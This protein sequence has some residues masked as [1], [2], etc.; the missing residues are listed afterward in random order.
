M[1]PKVSELRNG[2]TDTSVLRSSLPS[3]DT[4]RPELFRDD[5]WKP[6]FAKLRAEDPVHYCAESRHGPY[7]SV[8][9][10]ADIFAIETDTQTFSS[11]YLLGGVQ[12]SDIYNPTL[13]TMD[14]PDHTARRKAMTPVV[15]PKNL[16][17]FEKLIR[18]RTSAVLDSLPRN[19]EFDWVER[20]SIELT[21][22]MLATLF[23][24]PID[25]RQRLIHWSDVIAADLEDPDSPIRTE[26]ERMAVLGEFHSLMNDAVERSRRAPMRFDVISLLAHNDDFVAAPPEE[27]TTTFSVL[28]VGGNDT[29]RNS[30]SGGL[31]GLSQNP[32]QMELLKSRPDLVGNAVAE[33]IR[34]QTPVISM[35][36]TATRN[37]EL[38]GRQIQKGEKVVMWYVSGNRDESLFDD[39]DLIRVDRHNA[40]QHIAFGMGPHR[41]LGSRLAELQLRILWEEILARDL[42][43]EV[44]GAPSYAYSAFVRTV[45]SLPVK[46]RH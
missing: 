1:F 41:C 18:E 7:W 21:S 3:I 37:V 15:S 29:T 34:F 26:S 4:S 24:H 13:I 23:G 2:M 27:K 10:H 40:R 6:L 8:T 22:M 12:L 45:K 46:I 11:S 44:L 33:M 36:R 19:T 30:M 35:R 17:Q 31:W 38:H 14:A 28:L 39:A 16:A 20:V 9:R 43:I 5:L 25:D 42:D 32:G